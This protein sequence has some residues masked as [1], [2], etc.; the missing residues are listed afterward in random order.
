MIFLIFYLS[1]VLSARNSYL[2]SRP[3][4]VTW[5]SFNLTSQILAFTYPSYS[6]DS[7][8]TIKYSNNSKDYFLPS[9]SSTSAS[10][11]CN[12]VDGTVLTISY[13]VSI[14]STSSEYSSPVS[15]LCA[16]LP[17]NT[18]SISHSNVLRALTITWPKPLEN[19]SPIQGYRVKRFLNAW[20]LQGTVSAGDLSFTETVE[21]DKNYN[22]TVFAFNQVG[23]ALDSFNLYFNISQQ[24][25]A[26][27]S[28]IVKPELMR[29][30]Y[31]ASF[32]VKLLDEGGNLVLNPCLMV[33]EVRD[34]C[35]VVS[36]FECLRVKQGS[37]YYL[38]DLMA[39]FQYLQLENNFD[40]S[41]TGKIN[42]DL[43]GFYSFAVLQLQL[44]GVLVNFWDDIWFTNPIDSYKILNNFTFSYKDDELIT[45]YSSEY[46]SMKLFSFLHVQVPDNYTF[47]I[48][49]DDYFSFYIN[50]VL[51]FSSGDLCCQEL[52]FDY[53]FKYPDFYFLQIEVIQLDS[54]SSLSVD[55]SCNSFPRTSVPSSDLFWPKR[56][57]GSPWLQSV[58]IGLSSVLDCYFE[59][60][61]KFTAGELYLF[62]FYSV[63]KYN[64]VIENL[65]DVFAVE[66]KG[67]SE[68]FY[69]S[70]YDYKGRSFV[71]VQAGTAGEYEVSV[72]LYG[73]HVK[74]SPFNV[75]VV[76]GYPSVFH[77]YVDEFDNVTVA[78]IVL[79]Q[80]Y[81]LDY[82]GNPSQGGQV[83][84]QVIWLDSDKYESI[85]GVE[86]VDRSA[87]G[88]NQS[89]DFYTD[90]LEFSVFVAG[91]YEARVFLDGVLMKSFGFEAISGSVYPQH[92]V[93]VF[94]GLEVQ[95]G[96]EFRFQVQM[97]D[98]Y[99]NNVIMTEL[100]DYDLTAVSN[101]EVIGSAVVE[102]GV[103][104][105]V[106]NPVLT[107]VYK[108]VFNV[109]S[110][111]IDELPDFKVLPSNISY[112]TSYISSVSA[113]TTGSTVT[114]L[115]STKD[116]YE[117][118][119]AGG[120]SL[121][122]SIKGKT[123]LSGKLTDSQNGS[124]TLSFTPLLVDTYS[125]SVLHEGNQIGSSRTLTVT[126]SNVR[127]L[128][129]TL[130]SVSSVIAGKG[131]LSIT[132]RDL[133]GNSVSNPVNSLF[134]GSQY[135]YVNISGNQNLTVRASFT[136]LTAY[137][138]ALTTLTATGTYSVTLAL[139]EENGLTGF[140]YRDNE[141]KGLYKN[142]DYNNHV[143]Y[144]PSK[145][146]VKDQ[147]IN[148]TS[149]ASYPDFFSARWTGQLL[150]DLS[151]LYTFYIETDHKATFFIESTKIIDSVSAASFSGSAQLTGKVF[152]NI[153]IEYLNGGNQG[154]LVLKWAS[155]SF[156]KS[157]V[158][159][160]VLF[161]ETLAEAGPYTLR[162][163][164][165]S[166]VARMCYTTTYATDSDPM[167]RAYVKTLKAFSVF[168]RDSYG[169]QAATT[170]DVFVG[171]LTLGTTSLAISFVN[172]APGKYRA[173]FTP[174]TPG[175]Y[176]CRVS[177]L[178][179]NV[180]TLVNL[181]Y[182][183]VL[184]GPT[185]SS[186]TSVVDVPANVVVGVESGFAVIARDSA[187]TQQIKGGDSVK[188][189][190]TLG[191]YT[192]PTEQITVL[193][194][195]DGSYTVKF[196]SYVSGN[197]TTIITMNSIQSS[198]FLINI[199]SGS[200]SLSKSTISLP[201]PNTLGSTITSDIYL[202]DQ[203]SNPFTQS[204]AV[205]V[206]ITKETN[207]NFKPLKFTV[208][209]SDLTKGY[210][211]ATADFTLANVDRSGLCTSDNTTSTCNFIGSLTV[212]SG[213]FD[214]KV[215]G[216]Y[217]SSQDWTGT[218]VLSVRESNVAFSWD[219]KANGIDLTSFSA[220]WQGFIRPSSAKSYTLYLNADNYG[221]VWLD[222]VS[223]INQNSPS[224]S[225][226][227]KAGDY[228]R[229][230]VYLTNNDTIASVSLEWMD[231]TRTV[232]PS[233]VLFYYFDQKYISDSLLLFVAEA[234][235]ITS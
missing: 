135:Y 150:P 131:S 7:T 221:E 80:V 173:S 62:Q 67:P 123:S 166:T 48:Q 79:V 141:F 118:M 57:Q 169:N 21:Y 174:N 35:E 16:G 63:N 87:F 143:N 102:D 114:V 198:S 219:T 213:V 96:G 75:T 66:L 58:E 8:Y 159:A 132:S 30:G 186:K 217:Y 142:F 175:T 182:V 72:K 197:Y 145:Y 139:M 20:T 65:D 50:G 55:W 209:V 234:A 127:G 212:W 126:N 204:M 5:S 203:Y 176:T 172:E 138:I 153:T 157:V 53:D 188:V 105:A 18:S 130:N 200:L 40:G 191:T 230:E 69:T 165:D 170:T 207:S 44:N 196:L 37:E 206:Y 183:N 195:D 28:L 15:L 56:V 208:T 137:R 187:G 111:L 11:F 177:L 232:V 76:P 17:G 6:Q 201:S 33:L 151:G 144:V 190:M 167:V 146:T 54:E 147:A 218:E 70:T 154:F 149:F 84:L 31:E 97:R 3:S 60:E 4:P 185:D 215:L 180:Q 98:F 46:V 229:I 194:N 19:G 152:Y 1:P 86:Q 181:T 119:L 128:Y 23:E 134:M 78:Q 168:A 10:I 224:A 110:Q 38:N 47:Y 94:D 227:A 235:L 61:S 13:K 156:S 59:S 148:F 125:I 113:T 205:F 91:N 214:L 45:S 184:T 160:S 95:A 71:Y 22:Y 89:G 25:T 202:K 90:R 199:T 216:K 49:A 210:Y 211:K 108:I 100:K 162:V 64:Q 36:G 220:V 77:S 107:G 228:F 41:M 120:L 14:D 112:T 81:L 223:V 178:V 99:H 193:D 24:A 122:Y 73:Q 115:I 116:D 27:N 88:Y 140:Y 233:T 32:T 2:V 103:V 133:G 104:V 225:F 12:K 163:T 26:E 124:Y 226:T 121:T 129:S 85:L 171:T 93:G 231:A 179:S 82:F 68:Y 136:D 52:T 9:R 83:T 39:G 161:T 43:D 109:S 189:S 158:P 117:N 164:P 155:Q 42:V 74:A 106:F 101:E 92:C 51:V 222:G 34:V 29:S 192:L